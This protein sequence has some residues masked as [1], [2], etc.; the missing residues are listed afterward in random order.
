M[1]ALLDGGTPIDSKWR[2][3]QTALFIAAFRGHAGVVRV[4]LER[5]AKT[6]T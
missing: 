4:L 5:G 1:K 2:Y 3:D 6:P